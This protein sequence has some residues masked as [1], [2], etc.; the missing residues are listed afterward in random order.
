[1]AEPVPVLLARVAE[2]TATNRNTPMEKGLGI[3]SEPPVSCLVD[4]VQKGCN[5]QFSP[6]KVAASNKAFLAGLGFTAKTPTGAL[7]WLA[8]CIF[9]PIL[10]AA[11][12]LLWLLAASH[13]ITWGSAALG[14]VAAF[15]FFYG[16]FLAMR[17]AGAA[18]IHAK[19][20]DG[21]SFPLYRAPS[22][23]LSAACALTCDGD[24][25]PGVC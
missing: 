2:F 13:I 4:I 23:A 16:P 8:L 6:E 18:Y 10:L 20:T 1:M 17:S 7:T 12:I 25:C 15:I 22:A 21:S 24:T 5:P 19:L 3:L 11:L 14:S 9:L